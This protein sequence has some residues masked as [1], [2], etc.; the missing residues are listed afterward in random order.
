[1]ILINY[2]VEVD[3]VRED[4]V[5]ILVPFE[6]DEKCISSTHFIDLELVFHVHEPNNTSLPTLP[7]ST[8]RRKNAS[9]HVN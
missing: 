1:M 4:A 8:T 3:D 2:F 5:L 7:E 9:E 6:S